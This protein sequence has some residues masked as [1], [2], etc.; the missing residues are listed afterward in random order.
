LN[1][2]PMMAVASREFNLATL[3]MLRLKIH[4]HKLNSI[5]KTLGAKDIMRVAG[6]R[7]SLRLEKSTISSFSW[8]MSLVWASMARSVKPS[9]PRTCFKMLAQVA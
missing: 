1:Q 4:D 9:L 3:R 2:Y 8:T 7:S 5:G 6:R